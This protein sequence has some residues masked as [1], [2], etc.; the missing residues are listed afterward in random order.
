VEGPTGPLAQIELRFVVPKRGVDARGHLTDEGMVVL[1]G[2]RGDSKVRDSLSKGW[3]ALREQLIAGGMIRDTGSG[4][5]FEQDVLFSS[6]SA[7]AAVSGGGNWN[8]RLGW[9]NAEG[10]TL[11]ELEGGAPVEAEPEPD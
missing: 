10:A 3:R 11:A 7:A 2:S 6:P 5:V 9:R 4:I 8:G 1:R